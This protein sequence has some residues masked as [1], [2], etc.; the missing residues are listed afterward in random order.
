[1][2]TDREVPEDRAYPTGTVLGYDRTTSDNDRTGLDL[3]VD[4]ARPLGAARLEVG[5][6]GRIETLASTL[7]AE[8]AGPDGL[9]T[10]D[11]LRGSDFT[12]DQDVHAV[13][14]QVGRE[15][16]RLGLQAGLRAE[17]AFT[18]F[19]LTGQAEPF[20][21]R[22]PSLFPSAF[23]TYRLSDRTT[24]RGSYSRRVRRPR[25]RYLDPT[26][27]F[28]DP[29]NQ[30]V[31]N[32]ALE[33]EY[34]DA[35]EVGL[36]QFVP[37]GSVQ[38]TPFY[39]RTTNEIE[40]VETL[41]PEGVT[42]RR[43]ENFA[44]SASSGLEAVASLRGRGGLDGLRGTLSLEGYRTQ[45]DG[46]NV[47]TDLENDAFGW[48]GRASLTYALPTETDVQLRLRYRAPMN[49][50]QGRSGA[51][52]FLDLA[53]KQQLW[54]ER[55]SLTLR[56]RDPLGLASFDSLV[57]TPRLFQEVERSLGAREIG[58]AFT[59]VL[60]DADAR[61]QRQTDDAPDFDDAALD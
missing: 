30:R 52:T 55:A 37:W 19:R 8:T 1:M 50:A 17:A 5:Y 29:Q 41:T 43:P 7:V 32:P 56:A 20:E 54:T 61:R 15:V 11:L 23:A 13:Y 16:G 38:L 2:F 59:S 45:S 18:S 3:D 22:T 9:Y 24:L 25:T 34:T 57:D 42:L 49:T 28:D 36:V 46:S 6:A 53:V 51:R 31:G 12:Y 40:T 27:R 14:A 4:Y 10:P 44:T 60:G 39:R 47:E 58:V 21:N 33:P 48:G 26:P 35:V